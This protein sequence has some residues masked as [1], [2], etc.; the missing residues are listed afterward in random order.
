MEFSIKDQVYSRQSNS[1]RKMEKQGC[2]H[3][4]YRPCFDSAFPFN[5]Y[6]IVHSK[7]LKY[8]W[9]NLWILLVLCQFFIQLSGAG[10]DHNVCFARLLIFASRCFWSIDS[11]IN[12]HACKGSDVKLFQFGP[13]QTCSHNGFI[14]YSGGWEDVAADGSKSYPRDGHGEFCTLP[15]WKEACTLVFYNQASPVCSEPDSK[16]LCFFD[17]RAWKVSWI[18]KAFGSSF[19]IQQRTQGYDHKVRKPASPLLGWVELEMFSF[20]CLS[21]SPSSSGSGTIALKLTPPGLH[22]HQSNRHKF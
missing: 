15:S 5:N 19:L 8:I 21:Y 1:E 2:L 18:Y 7:V 22:D 12:Y 16:C 20:C 17:L 4:I 13:S 9:S 14:C 10:W 3:F 11:V 6:L